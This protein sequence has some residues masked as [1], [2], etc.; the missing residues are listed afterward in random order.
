MTHDLIDPYSIATVYL[1][2]CFNDV[3]LGPATGFFVKYHGKTYLITN[4]HV[5]SGR[6]ADTGAVLS[7]FAAIPNLIKVHI[8]RVDGSIVHGHL[9]LYTQDRQYWDGHPAGGAVDIAALYIWEGW[10][11]SFGAINTAVQIEEENRIPIIRPGM[12]L[13]VVGFPY[14]KSYDSRLPIWKSGHLAS[15]IG[16]NF[17]GKPMFLIDATTRSGMSGSPVVF[18]ADGLEVWP[19]GINIINGRKRYLLGVYSGRIESNKIS[20]TRRL[21]NDLEI[22]R[23]VKFEAIIDMLATAR[24]TATD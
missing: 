9:P 6:H 16:F 21:G 11:E 7:Q 15:E 13:S 22:S 10:F 23:V 17:D 1:E 8:R 5:V 20:D 2:A 3:V 14:G 24:R 4:Y 12:H 19:D 18:L